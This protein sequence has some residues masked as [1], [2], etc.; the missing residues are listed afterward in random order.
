MERDVQMST[1]CDSWFE[2]SLRELDTEQW[3]FHCLTQEQSPKRFVPVFIPENRWKRRRRGAGGVGFHAKE[4]SS[5]KNRILQKNRQILF[6]GRKRKWCRGLDHTTLLWRNKFAYTPQ[7]QTCRVSCFLLS[8]NSSAVTER[9]FRFGKPKISTFAVD[10]AGE[11]CRGLISDSA[12]TSFV[13]TSVRLSIG[14]KPRPKSALAP[15]AGFRDR[16]Y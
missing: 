4:G 7:D 3:I 11:R 10:L 15:T 1:F 14:V 2:D 8:F 6:G 12:F 5:V 13:L 16:G 9:G